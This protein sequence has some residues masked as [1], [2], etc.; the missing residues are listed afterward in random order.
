[1]VALF[2]V[3]FVC[4]CVGCGLCGMTFCW[5][6]V[7]Y[8]VFL[9]FGG[10]CFSWVWVGMALDGDFRSVCWCAVSSWFVVVGVCWLLLVLW[11]VLW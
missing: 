6:V 2:W 3:R 9:G 5:L 7:V 8:L 10:W 11:V 4:V 1:M